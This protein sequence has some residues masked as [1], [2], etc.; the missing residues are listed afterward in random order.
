MY[1]SSC[2]FEKNCYLKMNE[3]EIS[4][5]QVAIFTPDRKLKRR[6][7]TLQY[8][9]QVLLEHK[10]MLEQGIASI[11]ALAK[12]HL[13]Q[14]VVLREWLKKSDTILA[15]KYG[16]RNRTCGRDVGFFTFCLIF[17]SVILNFNSVI[18]I[19]F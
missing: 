2:D 6:S 13:I 18:L 12:K 14:P 4:S 16:M 5:A 10:Q 15:K 8:K 1:I 11:R 7:F 9:R 3:E 17:N 19:L